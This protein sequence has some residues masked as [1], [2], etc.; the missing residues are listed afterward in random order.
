MN[1]DEAEVQPEENVDHAVAAQ[2]AVESPTVSRLGT[3]TTVSVARL[4]DSGSGLFCL[5]GP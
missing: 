4:H 5:R 3:M 1:L 2:V